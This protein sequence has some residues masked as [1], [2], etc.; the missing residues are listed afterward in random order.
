ML[1]A[2]RQGIRTIALGIGLGATAAALTGTAAYAALSP[3]FRE[4]LVNKVLSPENLTTQAEKQEIINKTTLSKLSI[5]EE[6]KIEL[7]NIKQL[8]KEE[9]AQEPTAMLV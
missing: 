3:S 5:N 6:P 4:T 7:E 2:F 8:E 9:S 1:N